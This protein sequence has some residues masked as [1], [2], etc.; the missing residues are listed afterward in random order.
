MARI[1]PPEQPLSLFRL[2]QTV[3]SNPIKVWPAV[4]R[5]RLYRWRVLGQD[6]VYVMAPDL[7]RTVLLENADDFE[8]GEIT[9][10]AL[11]PGLGDSILIANGLRWRWQRRTVA[12]LFRPERIRE[13]VPE[14]IAAAER[15][16]DRWQAMP[17]GAEIDVAHEMML[18]TFD[19]ILRTILPG[20]GGDR[21]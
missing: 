12:A 15:I 21:Y 10:R 4:Y 11:G 5:E 20:R 13:F 9:R 6:T 7:I 19:V 2:L 18:T 16:R 8:K 3:V 1:E 17:P 14:I